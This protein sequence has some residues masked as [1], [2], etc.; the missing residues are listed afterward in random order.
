MLNNPF[1]PMRY[2]HGDCSQCGYPIELYED[3]HYMHDE[4]EICH[5]ECKE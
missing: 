1:D 5:K 3:V 4:V 2:T